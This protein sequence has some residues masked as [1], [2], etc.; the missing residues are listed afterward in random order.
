MIRFSLPDAPA[1][2]GTA[3]ALDLVVNGRVACRLALS[4]RNAWLYGIY[5]FSNDPRQ[6]KPRNF[7]DEIRVKDVPVAAGSVCGAAAGSL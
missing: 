5:P 4:S 7:Y 1:G 6:G 3:S 2:G